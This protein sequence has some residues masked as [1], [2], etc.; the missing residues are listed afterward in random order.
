MTLPPLAIAILC[1]AAGAAG[2]VDAIAGGGGLVTVPALMSFIPSP[3]LALG[4]NK[5][6][7]VFGAIS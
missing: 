7:A 3:H 1:V 5:G 2:F 4:T 6:Q